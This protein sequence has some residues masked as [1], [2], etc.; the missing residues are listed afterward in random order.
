MS[1]RARRSREGPVAGHALP[2][3]GLHVCPARGMLPPNS[4]QLPPAETG[5]N[6]A[7]SFLSWRIRSIGPTSWSGCGASSGQAAQ[8]ADTF[9]YR[10]W[11][12]SWAEQIGF[13]EVAFAGGSDATDH[14]PSWQTLA[15]MM[16]RSAQE[17]TKIA[18]DT[19]GRSSRFSAPAGQQATLCLLTPQVPFGPSYSFLLFHGTG[20]YK[21]GRAAPCHI[22]RRA[23][24]HSHRT[25][26]AIYHRGSRPWPR[27]KPR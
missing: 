3:V 18:F 17:S 16:K 4:G 6:M 21:S 15:A 24:V 22:W 12:R 8:P 20:H 1:I 23:S 27:Q 5:G 2:L 19:P 14:S 7:F 13:T 25:R 11:I 9:L 10:D 26:A